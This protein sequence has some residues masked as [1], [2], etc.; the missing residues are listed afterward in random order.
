MGHICEG[1]S[2]QDNIIVHTN[3]DV[4]RSEASYFLI[5][6]ISSSNLLIESLCSSNF[7]LNFFKRSFSCFFMYTFSWALSSSSNGP[8]L[9]LLNAVSATENDSVESWGVRLASVWAI[10][11]YVLSIYNYRCLK[12]NTRYLSS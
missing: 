9:W 2:S 4:N 6:L 7:S 8:P 5:F 1:D 12:R 10:I 3:T 11:L